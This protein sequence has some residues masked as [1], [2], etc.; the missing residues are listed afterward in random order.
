MKILLSLAFVAAFSASAVEAQTVEKFRAAY[1]AIQPAQTSLPPDRA[2]EAAVATAED[3][4]WQIV[5]AVPSEGRIEAIAT[6]RWWGFKD[7][8]VIRIRPDDSGSRLDIRST[9]RV[10]LGD[11]GT[12]AARVE[13]FLEDFEGRVGEGS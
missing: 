2:F 12:N 11:F 4:D 9:S 10:G 3:Q 6:T 8:V 1:P 13:A 5:A 7:D